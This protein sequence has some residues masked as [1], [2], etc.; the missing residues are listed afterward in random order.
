MI[1]LVGQPKFTRAKKDLEMVLKNRTLYKNNSFFADY[2]AW[3]V[4]DGYRVPGI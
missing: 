2:T 1:L 3:P 4:A